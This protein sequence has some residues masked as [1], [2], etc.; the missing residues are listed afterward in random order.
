MEKLIHPMMTKFSPSEL[1][2]IHNKRFFIV[3]AAATKKIELILSI[4]RDEIAEEIR[5]RSLLFPKE[6]D[7]VNGK[8]F[9]GENYRG[10]P[11]LVLDYP[12]H[13]SKDS[14]L[15]FRTMFWWGNY[16]SFT[17]H[18]QGHALKNERSRLIEN[19]LNL[20]KRGIYIC[21]GPTPWEYHYGPDNYTLTQKLGEKKLNSTLTKKDFIK[22]SV[23][24]D[25]RSSAKLPDTCRS[26]F[27]LFYP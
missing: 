26:T 15:A 27:R 14:V 2:A 6:V 12:K 22:L 24:L 20:L 7:V 4:V 23:K 25:L 17:M 8:I 18:L 1:S 9:R 16:F 10:L 11:Y 13:F 21:T 5:T 19:H 3:K